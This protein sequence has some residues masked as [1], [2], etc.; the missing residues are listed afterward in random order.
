MTLCEVLALALVLGVLDPGTVSWT[1][2]L[3]VLN[4]GTGCLSLR[5]WYWVSWTL[6]LFFGTVSWALV[7]G[8]VLC[9]LIPGIG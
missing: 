4:P 9:V 1:L 2:T 6:V 7:L 8:V 3:G 5:P